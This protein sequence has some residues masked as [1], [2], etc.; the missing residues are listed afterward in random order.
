MIEK[1]NDGTSKF[2]SNQEIFMLVDE[3]FSSLE[4][5]TFKN[6]EY[7]K[8]LDKVLGY[9]DRKNGD[10]TVINEVLK[11]RNFKHGFYRLV[12]AYN[13]MVESNSNDQEYYLTKNGIEVVKMGSIEKYIRKVENPPLTRN[14]WLTLILSSLAVLIAAIPKV[15]EWIWL[16]IKV[17]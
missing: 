3:V 2:P 6:I 10:N 9:P 14:E 7:S 17:F 5:S 13:L 8:E 4:A 12:S 11:I 15:P 16:W 1:Y